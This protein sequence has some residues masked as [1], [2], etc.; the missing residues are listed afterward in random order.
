MGVSVGRS[1]MM[2]EMTAVTE[3]VEVVEE[4]G[5]RRADGEALARVGSDSAAVARLVGDLD[6]PITNRRPAV[7][8]C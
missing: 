5:S 8:E 6:D 3:V 4:I 1:T 2:V 7:E